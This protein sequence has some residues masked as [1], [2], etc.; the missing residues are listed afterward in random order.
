MSKKNIAIAC[1]G[2]GSHTAFTAGVLH[3]LLLEGVHEEYNITELSGT[4]GGAICA[5]AVWYGLLKYAAGSKE[6][7]YKWLVKIWED[8][9]TQSVWEK[10]LNNF[11]INTVHLQDAGIIPSY[12][13][14]PY[15]NQWI[16]DFLTMISP[17][18]EYINLRELLENHIDFD[19]IKTLVN[20]SSPT[21]LLGA[22]NILSGDF[23]AFDSRKGEIIVE[24]VMA[25]AAIPNVFPAVHIGQDAYWDGLFSKNPPVTEFLTENMVR[26]PDE[27][28]IIQINPK[29]RGSEPKTAQDILD[30]RNELAGN[31]SLY[32]EVNF[33]ELVNKWI[34][35]G[36]FEGTPLA[37]EIKPID[38]RW[39]SMS[40]DLAEELDYSSKLNRDDAFIQ[41]LMSNGRQQAGQFL[42]ILRGVPQ[43]A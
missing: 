13:P 29:T 30:R 11:V 19:E 31:L 35:A 14:N 9:S 1:Q 21:L 25:S 23:K 38:I 28:W 37:D 32:Q 34:R 27:I 10:S 8:N 7:P 24:A 40:H 3:D 36:I 5:T 39:I 20:S 6:P 41:K 16:V 22:V 17:R 33:I 15:A 12:P 4:S 42:R 43:P 2:G 18:K 26:R